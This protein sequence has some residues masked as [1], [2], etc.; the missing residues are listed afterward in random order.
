[1]SP[2]PRALAFVRAVRFIE[3]DP[4]GRQGSVGVAAVE[5]ERRGIDR[6]CSAE[7]ADGQV[8]HGCHDL[9][10]A[11]PLE[12]E[13]GGGVGDV[14]RGIAAASAARTGCVTYLLPPEVPCDLRMVLSARAITW[15][16]DASGRGLGRDA[17][18]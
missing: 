7:H 6:S 10:A 13:A 9:R 3:P 8:A 11:L 2:V 18:G 1:M 12:G 4:E 17:D 15:G 14:V 16:M 5:P